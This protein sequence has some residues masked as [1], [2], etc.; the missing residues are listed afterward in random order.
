M[1]GNVKI[2]V[3]RPSIITDAK[4]A[5]SIRHPASLHVYGIFPNAC[6]PTPPVQAKYQTAFPMQVKSSFLSFSF[7]HHSSRSNLIKATHIPKLRVLI[8]KRSLHTHITD[9]AQMPIHNLTNHNLSILKNKRLHW[10]MREI[11]RKI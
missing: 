8:R 2:E 3:V 11:D 6:N 1:H 4:P 5:R 10:I 7:R 9:V